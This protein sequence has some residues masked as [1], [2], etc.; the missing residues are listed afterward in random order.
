[1]DRRNV[2][3]L[4]QKLHH[5]SRG[6]VIAPTDPGARRTMR[7]GADVVE[8]VQGVQAMNRLGVLSIVLA[9]A[10]TG[11]CGGSEEVG[12]SPTGPSSTPTTT[13]SQPQPTS[14]GSCVPANLVVSAVQGSVVTL[15]WSAVSGASE[16]A[17][18]VGSTPSS[19]D[20]LS[21]NTSNATYTWTAQPG[22]QFARVQAKCG[23]TWGGS[24]NEAEFTVAGSSAD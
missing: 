23:G 9:A 12:S 5:T 4:G 15:Q 16:Y 6:T 3:Q 20:Q 11:A 1:L 8:R 18:L 10:V 17:I 2:D 7:G 19:S 13:S 21:T 22:R 24:S 14:Q